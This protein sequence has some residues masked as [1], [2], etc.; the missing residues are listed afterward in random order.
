M[1]FN[2]AGPPAP[3]RISHV[4]GMAVKAF[5]AAYQI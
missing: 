1:L 5:L 4:V 2:A 3:A